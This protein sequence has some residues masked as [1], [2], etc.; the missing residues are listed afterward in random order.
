ML[1]SSLLTN[2]IESKSE[3]LVSIAIPTFNQSIFLDLFFKEHIFLLKKFNIPI[4]IS[5]NASSDS[6]EIIVKKWQ[7]EFHLI[8]YY[9]NTKNIGYDKNVLS[10]LGHSKTKYT[11]LMGDTYFISIELLKKVLLEIKKFENLDFLVVNL[12]NMNRNTLSQVYTDQNRVLSDLG[13]IMTC[14]SC[15]I[16]HKK[17]INSNIDNLNH[18]SAFIHLE[19]ILNYINNKN[20]KAVWIADYSVKSLKHPTIKKT[21]WS[22]KQDV[23]EIG[24]K[25]WVD[26]I[27]SLPTTYSTKDKQNCIRSFGKL[28]KLG[29]LRG[30]LLIRMRGHL[31]LASYEKYKAEIDLV[32]TIPSFLVRLIIL[33]PSAFLKFCFDLIIKIVNLKS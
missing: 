6:T 3:S 4:T 1:N 33:V 9:C 20:F 29:T 15:L 30:F 10:V 8:S 21:N 16:Y 17:V 28:S 19:M 27:S 7:K 2:D 22:H 26:F 5:D 31:T 24:F 11:W 23:L 12:E 32:R 14:L 18:S 13:G 25:K